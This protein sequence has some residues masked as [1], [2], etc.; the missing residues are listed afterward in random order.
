MVD[1]PGQ[2]VSVC[3]YTQYLTEVSTPTV[4]SKLRTHKDELGKPFDCILVRIERKKIIA[5]LG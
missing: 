2:S 3:V 1:G 5:M 4:P